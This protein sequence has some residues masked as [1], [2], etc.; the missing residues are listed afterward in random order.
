MLP[1]GWVW[2]VLTRVR[3]DQSGKGSGGGKP[4]PGKVVTFVMVWRRWI[5]WEINTAR[6]G[7]EYDPRW[8]VR[9]WVLTRERDESRAIVI[10]A[11]ARIL[12]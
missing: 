5:L 9:S 11:S 7:V 2:D 10:S 4:G 8:R 6:L 3:L 1:M 12:G